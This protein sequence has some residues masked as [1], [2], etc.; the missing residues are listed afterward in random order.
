M[1]DTVLEDELLGEDPA[2][3]AAWTTDSSKPIAFHAV[4]TVDARDGD[5][6][7]GVTQAE[8]LLRAAGWRTV[9]Q[10][11]VTT[12]AT[13]SPSNATDHIRAA[14]APARAGVGAVPV[15]ES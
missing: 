15:K 5:D 11:D 10:W 12:S 14:P 1:D 4:T 2:D 6:A 13:S 8:E 7:D 9:G 3:H